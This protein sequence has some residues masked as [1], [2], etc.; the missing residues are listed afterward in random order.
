MQWSEQ[1][2][3][4]HD[5]IEGSLF[6]KQTQS[7]NTLFLT[8]PQDGEKWVRVHQT[9]ELCDKEELFLQCLTEKTTK[10]N[11]GL[12]LYPDLIT[13]TQLLLQKAWRVL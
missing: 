7:K 6:H 11:L 8:C 12:F 9:S 5:Q 1:C 10:T 13:G 3:N 2:A 4:Y